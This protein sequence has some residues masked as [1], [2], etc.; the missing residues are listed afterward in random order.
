MSP[1]EKSLSGGVEFHPPTSSIQTPDRES[2]HETESRQ[3]ATRGGAC[4]PLRRSPPPLWPRFPC[5]LERTCAQPPVVR[6]ALRSRHVFRK[7]DPA[8]AR[9][10]VPPRGTLLAWAPSSARWYS[11]KS[12]EPPARPRRP[13]LSGSERQRSPRSTACPRPCR[14]GGGGGVAPCAAGT[15]VVGALV[16][17]PSV[18][19]RGA[20]AAVRARAR[21]ARAAARPWTG[22]VAVRGAP[23]A[24]RQR[25]RR[26]RAR[27]PP[28]RRRQRPPRPLLAGGGARP[29][30]R[31][32]PPAP[33]AAR[34]R[35]RAPSA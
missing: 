22:L 12:R 21:G 18:S 25:R 13:P 3:P 16:V 15:L 17:V 28:R 8:A 34:R 30:R 26:R 1:R 32:A 35:A 33:S 27:R 14:P 31:P 29:P 2:Q 7:T 19:Q 9:R 5:A 10:R 24:A 11:P 20:G 4:L 23:L 6:L